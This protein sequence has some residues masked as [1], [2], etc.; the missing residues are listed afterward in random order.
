MSFVEV[1]LFGVY[2]APMSLMMIG[3]YGVLYLFRKVATRQGWFDAIWY[4]GLF[5]V[6]LYLI[7]LSAIV[8]LT[9]SLHLYV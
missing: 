7:I 6:A 8:L 3:A 4:P 1:D 9:A 5:E 2:V